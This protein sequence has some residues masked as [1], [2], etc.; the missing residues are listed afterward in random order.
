MSTT[1][2]LMA[3]LAIG[4]AC[5]MLVAP[6]ASAITPLAAL[7]RP[8]VSAPVVARRFVP[9]AA[10]WLSGHRG[11]DLQAQAGTPVLA[12]A[13]GVV[14]FVG[15]VAGRGVVTL[16]HGG[17][18]TSYEPI[19]AVVVPGQQ[20]EVGSVIGTVGTGSGHC[21]SGRCLHLGVRRGTEYL[22][23]LLLLAPV[24]SRLLPW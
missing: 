16:D 14:S 22:D 19:D 8:P 7:W 9:P 4:A 12:P 24:R 5:A 1:R 17:L 2:R 21:G 23:P 13:Q 3:S 20:V 15:S 18:R 10:P 6:P 11:I